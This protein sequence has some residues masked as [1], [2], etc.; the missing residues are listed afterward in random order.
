MSFAQL[1]TLYLQGLKFEFR[2]LYLFI[3]RIKI[4]TIKLLDKNKIIEFRTLYL[5]ILRIKFFTIKLLDKNKI[6]F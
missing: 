6:M 1:I 5:F 3:L 4:F 2:T